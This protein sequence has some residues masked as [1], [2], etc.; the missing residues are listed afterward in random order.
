MS[1]SRREHVQRGLLRP[2]DA[3][4]W[5]AMSVRTLYRRVAEGELPGPVRNG[6]CSRFVAAEVAAYVERLKERRD[7]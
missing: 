4:E 6:G 1:E 3:A 7:K 2:T 5:L